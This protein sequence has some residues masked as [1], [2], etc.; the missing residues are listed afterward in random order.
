MRDISLQSQSD[1]ISTLLTFFFQSEK[2]ASSM[3]EWDLTPMYLHPRKRG[4]ER[5]SGIWLRWDLAPTDL[6][7]S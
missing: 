6:H 1:E 4:L 3:A 5:Q 2:V 7:P